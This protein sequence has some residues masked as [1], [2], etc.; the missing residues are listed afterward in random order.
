[1]GMV[2]G[3]VCQGIGVKGGTILESDYPHVRFL[4]PLNTGTSSVEVGGSVFWVPIPTP[5]VFKVE[6]F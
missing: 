4:A 2:G 1:M 5:E 6:L 3:G